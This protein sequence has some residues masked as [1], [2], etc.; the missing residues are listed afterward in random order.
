MTTVREVRTDTVREE[1]RTRVTLP[2]WQLDVIANAVV[3]ALFTPNPH[4]D[5][6]QV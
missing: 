6:V 4:L 2:D 5:N 3:N 1:I